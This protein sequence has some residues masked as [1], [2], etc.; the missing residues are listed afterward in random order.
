MFKKAIFM[1]ALASPAYAADSADLLKIIATQQAE[2]AALKKNMPRTWSVE[3]T[4]SKSD[5]FT[6]TAEWKNLPGLKLNYELSQASDVRLEFDGTF[7]ARFKD[8]HCSLAFVV[9]GVRLGNERY[10]STIVMGESGTHWKPVGRSKIIRKQPAGK[11]EVQLAVTSNGAP[12]GGCTF[13][14]NDHY[15]VFNL[16]ATTI[17]QK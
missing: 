16:H 15:S 4:F 3:Q 13:R 1:L 7:Y 14:T 8:E 10:G 5:D 12:V 17:N 6:A 9:N 2:I 11:Y